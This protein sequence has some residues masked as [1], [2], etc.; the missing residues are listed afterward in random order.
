MRAEIKELHQRLKTTTIYVTHDQIEAMTMA[1]RIV[2]MRDG[3]I[4]QLG[5]PLELYDRPANEFVAG[6]I[7]SPSM[8][9]I[10]GVAAD[11]GFRTADGILLPVRRPAADATIYG[12]RPEHLRIDQDGFELDIVVIE[13]MG[14]ETQIVAKL[15]KQQIVGIFRER[16][17]AVPGGK[18]RVTPDLDMVH[19]FGRDGLRR[20]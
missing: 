7:G 20:N 6:F 8:N 3:V 10:S 18:I 15:G 2:V 4:E 1:D 13:P 14:S 12:I 19:L 17:D 11:G 5:T 16:F 9:F